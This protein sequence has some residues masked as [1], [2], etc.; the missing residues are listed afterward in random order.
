M[1]P[2]T[3]LLSADCD[4]RRRHLCVQRGT[5]GTRRHLRSHARCLRRIRTAP[6]FLER[7]GHGDAGHAVPPGGAPDAPLASSH[8]S[9]GR[10]GAFSAP[11][12][13]PTAHDGRSS[14]QSIWRPGQGK[15][16]L[17]EV[18]GSHSRRVLWLGQIHT[19]ASYNIV[20]AS[21]RSVTPCTNLMS[22]QQHRPQPALPE[23]DP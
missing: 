19:F 14:A 22:D 6:A 20:M 13:I 23:C 12:C 4:A 11:F 17:K 1:L 7:H 15:V 18:L 16:F 2:S 5:E 21:R 3:V 8:G 10:G 9:A